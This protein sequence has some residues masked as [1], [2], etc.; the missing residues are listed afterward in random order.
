MSFLP[1]VLGALIVLQAGLN[2]K[3]AA[4]WGLPRAVLFNALVMT[5]CASLFLAWRIWRAHE[6]EAGLSYDFKHFAFWFLLPG[7][8][9]FTLVYGGPWSILRWGAVHTF[10]LVI[11]AQIFASMLWDWRV[12]QLPISWLRL[13]GVALTWLGVLIAVRN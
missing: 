2:R 12:E 11:S 6:S 1:A 13:L 9:G 5:V 4:A 10:L 3:V 7:T 8:L